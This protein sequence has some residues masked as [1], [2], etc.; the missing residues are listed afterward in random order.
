MALILAVRAA[1]KRYPAPGGTTVTA[2]RHCS[3]DI[4]GGSFTVILG[5]SGCGKTTLLRI[6]AGLETAGEGEVLFPGAG[7][8]RAGTSA[9]RLR[10][11]ASVPRMGFM[12]Q[13]PRLLPWMTVEQNL[14]LAFSPS[15]SRAEKQGVRKEIRR[16]L[17]LV[18][19]ADRAAAYPGELSGGMAQRAAL[20]RCLCRK[21]LLLLLDEPLSSLDAFTRLR[22]RGELERIWQSLALTVLLVT[23][24][25]EEAVFFGGRILLMDRGSM[26][27]EFSVSLPRPRDYHSPAFREQCRIIEGAIGV[28]GEKAGDACLKEEAL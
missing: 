20:A 13:D 19:L 10:A 11:G 28:C 8:D 12:F 21:P 1:G 2:L 25:I 23:H 6:I 4:S 15:G 22:L 26:V 16:I 17:A 18:G 3:L 7:E 9:G 27:R 5:R 14:A 24:D